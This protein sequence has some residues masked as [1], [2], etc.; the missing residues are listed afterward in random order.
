M[1]EKLKLEDMEQYEKIVRLRVFL[2]V[3]DH[4]FFG[5]EDEFFND[6]YSLDQSLEEIKE[7]LE[8]EDGG[9]EYEHM[10]NEV[11]EVIEANRRKAASD[12]DESTVADE[13]E[14]QD[15]AYNRLS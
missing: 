6:P 2:F 5:F 9:E 8:K 3:Y 4:Y 15:K 11:N 14:R 12:Y 10:I 7:W 1:K 13:V